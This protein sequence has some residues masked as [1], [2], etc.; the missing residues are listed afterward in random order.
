MTE[1]L[2]QF[3]D[4][5]QGELSSCQ[6]KTEASAFAVSRQLERARKK[7]R[8]LKSGLREAAINSFVATNERVRDVKV[9]LDPYVE[10]NAKHFITV[11]LERF[12]SSQ[13]EDAIQTAL[14]LG[15]IFDHWKFG[16]GASNGVRGTHAVDKIHQPMTC[17]APCEP[18]VRKLRSM[19]PY[20]SRFDCENDVS[21][22]SLVRG[23]R[24]ATVPKN[25]DT[26]RTIAIEPSGQMALQLAAG[27]YLEGVL[28]YLGLDI[29]SQQPK[30]R[31]AA[32]R[33]SI[34]NGL[35]TIDL[36][37]ASD[38]ISLELVRRLFPKEW[39]WLL[40]TLRSRE[41]M[42]PSGEWIK[43]HMISTMGNGFT[44]P[45]MTLILSA[46]IYGYRCQK[47]GKDAPNLYIDWTDTC[48]FGDD[49]IVPSTEY[50]DVCEVLTQAGLIVNY[51]KSFSDGPFRESCGG[52]FFKGV[53]VTPFYVKDL[54]EPSQVY[55]AINQVLEW[56]EKTKVFLH[57]TL[58]L[59]K[60]YLGRKVFLVPEWLNP[61]Q[62]IL[63]SQVGRRYSYLQPQ[64][65]RR[66]LNDDSPF[67]MMLAVG[68]YLVPSGPHLFYSPRPKKPKWKV[69][70]SRL[71]RGY[72]DG[73]EP[74]KRSQLSSNSIAAN[75]AILF[76]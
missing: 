17:N 29:R 44:F 38:M 70:T 20:I 75:V 6:P 52:D 10:A 33:G 8:I 68:G 27:W 2:L 9:T 3:F 58:L 43:M 76:G 71:P 22:V 55:V 72:L 59:L 50:S 35:A 46:L 19:N 45:L 34:S 51:D 24:L 66:R 30:N 62:G 54:S 64:P 53:D 26:E 41:I 32:R 16:P 14:D 1:R 60:S 49:V 37:S 47:Y 56:C 12:T 15:L 74:R 63:T 5:L 48:V 25:E 42:L 11:M 65:L 31:D 67:A 23:S 28:R 57:Q 7:A 4:T 61:D 69:R 13:V 40:E 21:G 18:L 73:W 39:I 36:K